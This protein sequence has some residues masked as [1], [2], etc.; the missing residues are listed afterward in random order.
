MRRELGGHSA[1]DAFRGV[2]DHY[3]G[4]FET[5]EDYV[6]A[7]LYFELKTFLH[8]L[9]VVEDKL[10]MA[11]SLET[12]VPFLDND[13]VDFACRVPASYKL[14][15]LGERHAGRRERAGQ[16]AT[17]PSTPTA[18]RYCARRCNGTAAGGHGP[19]QAGVQRPRREL[20]PRREHRLHQPPARNPKARIYEFVKPA[21]VQRVLDEHSSGKTNRR[22]LIWSLLSLEWW[23]RSFLESFPVRTQG[24]LYAFV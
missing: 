5:N 3:P 8:G 14:R 20:V 18:R 21:Y 13:L 12:R 16:A 15:D 22:L 4:Q 10:S 23:C 7:S 19:Q 6:N 17:R 1:F 24:E 9:L 11:H 2:F